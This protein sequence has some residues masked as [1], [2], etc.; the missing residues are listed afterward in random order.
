[1]LK[2][3]ES[4]SYMERLRKTGSLSQERS[5][6]L[7]NVPEEK[8]QRNQSQTLPWSSDRIKGNGHKLKH[9][10]FPLNIREHF[11]AMRVTKHWCRLSRETV[12][13]SPL[14]ILETHLEMVLRNLMYVV[15]LEPEQGQ[16]DF[17][18]PLSISPIP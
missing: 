13:S 6:D 4:V 8:M 14:E 7:T 16:D 3:L 17:Q 10:M 15:L 5:R 12:E 2:K 18:R 1:M 9:R 11:F